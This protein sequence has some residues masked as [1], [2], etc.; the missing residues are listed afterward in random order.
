MASLLSGIR[1]IPK[2]NRKGSEGTEDK[3]KKAQSETRKHSSHVGPREKER[4]KDRERKEHKK[5]R[6]N[7]HHRSHQDSENNDTYREDNFN[8][9]NDKKQFER[10]F[11]VRNYSAEIS[12]SDSEPQPVEP[13]RREIQR[14]IDVVLSSYQE[15]KPLEVDNHSVAKMLRMRLANKTLR[16]VVPQTDA[17]QESPT[18]RESDHTTDL[19]VQRLLHFQKL[20]SI[21]KVDNMRVRESLEEDMDKTL[22]NDIVRRIGKQTSGDRAGRDEDEW[23]EPMTSK[24]QKKGHSSS[25]KAD[26]NNSTSMVEQQMRLQ[27]QRTSRLQSLVDKCWRCRGLRAGLLEQGNAAKKGSDESQ[28]I[29]MGE[30]FALRLKDSSQSIAAG[31]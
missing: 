16:P 29:C 6:H 5:S 3:V 27:A 12:D 10:N 15:Q 23:D 8:G 25:S 7:H 28:I 17:R 24:R 4:H 11:E 31:N 30:H 2:E 19:N 21:G 1:F 22:A 14:P 9:N 13:E 20:A 26:V 18:V